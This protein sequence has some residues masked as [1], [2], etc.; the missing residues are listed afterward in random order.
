MESR[1]FMGSITVAYPH[2]V[3][4]GQAGM[5]RCD[6]GKPRNHKRR[7][8]LHT[9]ISSRQGRLVVA[10]RRF[11]RRQSGGSRLHCS[12]EA[13]TWNRSLWVIL[14][15]FPKNDSIVILYDAHV[16]SPFYMDSRIQEFRNLGIADYLKPLRLFHFWKVG[17]LRLITRSSYMNSEKW[18]TGKA[19]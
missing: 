1:A 3:A 18:T 10:Q 6:D 4:P 9:H 15:I 12:G 13:W 2:A 7:K 11:I 8:Q 16:K 5:S 14:K 17:K 19:S